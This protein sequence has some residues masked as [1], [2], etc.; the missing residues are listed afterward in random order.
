M[1]VAEDADNLGLM[2][3][4]LNEYYLQARIS[5]NMSKSEY[6]VVV[7]DTVEDLVLENNEHMKGVEKY[8]YSN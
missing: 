4:K 6:L 2:I 8:K 3:R 1:L 5:I 7:N